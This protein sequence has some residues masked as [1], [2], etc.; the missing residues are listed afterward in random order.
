MAPPL[1]WAFDIA[2]QTAVAMGRPGETPAFL[3]IKFSGEDQLSVCASCI[4]W[5]ARLLANPPL[6]DV[7]YLEMPMRLGAAIHGKSNAASILRLNT[8]YGIIGGALLLR[9][10]RVIGIEVQAVRAAFIGEGKLE[11]DEAKRRCLNMCRILNWPAANKDEGDAGAIW[12]WGSACESPRLA[13]IVHPGL[14]AKVASLT[15]SQS[16]GLE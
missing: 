6:P 2:T 12:Y 3:T 10:V 9:G 11:R 13:A 1:I 8:L 5:V 7:A 15:I 16:L 4:G 14:H